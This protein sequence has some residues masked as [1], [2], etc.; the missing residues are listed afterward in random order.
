MQTT[1]MASTPV[2]V[3]PSVSVFSTMN[4]CGM[5]QQVA[6][7]VVPILSENISS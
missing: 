2:T 6:K 1:P 5:V 3:P 7:V 4:V